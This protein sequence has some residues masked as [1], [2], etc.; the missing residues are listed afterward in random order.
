[1][2]HV[3][4]THTPSL[5]IENIFIRTRK[6]TSLTS[7]TSIGKRTNVQKRKVVRRNWRVCGRKKIVHCLLSTI[8]LNIFSFNKGKHRSHHHHQHR[9]HLQFSWVISSLERLNSVSFYSCFAQ[10]LCGC[11][12]NDSRD[13]ITAITAC[14]KSMNALQNC[15][16][17]LL[18]FFCLL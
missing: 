14:S 12:D 11:D 2:L 9:Q 10:Y 8:K 17:N 13:A 15:T 6:H 18:L 1:M 16:F 7:I 5:V 3:R 4:Q